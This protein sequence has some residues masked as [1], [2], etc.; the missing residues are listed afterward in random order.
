MLL[1][2]TI[3][4]QTPEKKAQRDTEILL[5]DFDLRPRT[6]CGKIKIKKSEIARMRNTT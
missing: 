2:T 1:V 3:K 6:P 4:N 5:S